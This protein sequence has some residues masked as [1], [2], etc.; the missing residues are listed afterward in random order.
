MKKS[1]CTLLFLGSLLVSCTSTEKKSE[2]RDELKKSLIENPVIVAKDAVKK[3]DLEENE[4]PYYHYHTIIKKEFKDSVQVNFSSLES[5]DSFT[6]YMPVGNIDSTES[7][8]RIYNVTGE[9][10]YEKIFETHELIN[11]YDLEF[12]KNETQ[13]Q[14]YI[15]DKAKNMLDKT[16]FDDWSKVKEDGIIGQSEPEDFENYTTYVECKKDKRMLFWIN[17]GEEDGTCI[18]FSKKQNKVLDIIYCC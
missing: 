17:L 6:F 8:L 12:I 7:I 18:G 3:T 13:M 14:K 1:I 9:L 10:I 4:D 2:H 16:S 5:K 15:Y 11:G